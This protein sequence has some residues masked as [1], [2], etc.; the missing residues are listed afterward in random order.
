MT[1]WQDRSDRDRASLWPSP[2]F[3]HFLLIRPLSAYSIKD[4]RE[5]SFKVRMYGCN[6]YLLTVI[7][8][9]PDK[10]VATMCEGRPTTFNCDA[11]AGAVVLPNKLHALATQTTRKAATVTGGTV[12]S[13]SRFSPLTPT[14][15][16][17][18]AL[19]AGSTPHSRNESG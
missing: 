16:T 12:A 2:C 19:L 3:D 4:R 7:E 8:C 15:N 14:V 17:G 18:A 9:V 1:F 5:A 10:L 6:L 13:G 11:S